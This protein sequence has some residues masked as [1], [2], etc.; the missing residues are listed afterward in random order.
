MYQT[1]VVSVGT[2]TAVVVPPEALS[3][4]GMRSGDWVDVTVQGEQIVIRLV[5]REAR[6]HQAEAA[7]EDVLRRRHSAYHRLA[8]GDEPGACI[9][10]YPNKD[11]V[12]ELQRRLIDT[13]GGAHGL[14]DEG[15]LDS[16]LAAPQF[17]WHYEGEDLVGCAATSPT[18]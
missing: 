18:T 12:V 8:R 5:D 9:V 7:V 15:L 11:E 10:L 6:K 14:R 4:V 16:A 1:P 17:R 13:F 3:A 2:A